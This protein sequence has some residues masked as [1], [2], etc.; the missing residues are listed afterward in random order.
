MSDPSTSRRGPHIPSRFAGRISRAVP[1][2]DDQEDRPREDPSENRR[3]RNDRGPRGGNPEHRNRRMM[4]SLQSALGGPKNGGP[5]RGARKEAPSDDSQFKVDSCDELVEKLEKMNVNVDMSA[6]ELSKLLTVNLDSLTEEEMDKVAECLCDSAAHHGNAYCIVE[7]AVA[8]IKNVSFQDAFSHRLTAL[9]TDYIFETDSKTDVLPEFLGN[10]LVANY[11]RP[12]H[13]AID[14]SNV[15]LFTI[16]SSV[17]G[18]LMVLGGDQK[19]ADEDAEEEENPPEMVDRC[20]QALHD[21]CMAVQ[22][23]LWIKWPELVDEIYQGIRPA[24]C[25]NT[26]LSS[27]MKNALLNVLIQMHS[28]SKAGV[29]NRVSAQTQTC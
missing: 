8:V 27:K 5:R 24:I 11:P 6:K 4:A 10:L 3:P 2:H 17:K 14:G 1:N 16:I 15:I 23:R 13:R 7:L 25:E 26:K 21:L 9:I 18:W 19:E 29:P 20:A 22:R 12:H 28:W